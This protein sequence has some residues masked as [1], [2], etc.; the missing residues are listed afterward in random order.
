MAFYLGNLPFQ[1]IISEKALFEDLN[2]ITNIKEDEAARRVLLAP[3][4]TTADNNNN[5]E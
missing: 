4:E 5:E 2:T 1:N 3:S